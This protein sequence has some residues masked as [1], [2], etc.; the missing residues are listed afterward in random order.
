MSTYNLVDM[1]NALVRGVV[2][3]A[4]GAKMTQAAI[5]ALLECGTDGQAAFELACFQAVELAGTDTA[6]LAADVEKRLR[7]ALGRATDGQATIKKVKQGGELVGYKVAVRS[8]RE[9]DTDP[10]AE[11]I[12]SIKKLNGLEKAEIATVLSKLD[13][14]TLAVI[15]ELATGNEVVAVEHDDEDEAGE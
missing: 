12:K 5:L 8:T 15:L 11:A 6:T 9:T 2:M 7:T 13:A 10:L 1:R 3:E 4:Q 14:D